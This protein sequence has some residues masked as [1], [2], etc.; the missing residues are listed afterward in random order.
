MTPI[1]RM[2]AIPSCIHTPISVIR[3]LIF[4]VWRPL[5]ILSFHKLSNKEPFMKK[6]LFLVVPLLLLLALLLLRPGAQAAPQAAPAP[7]PSSVNALNGSWE[8]IWRGSGAIFDVDCF[9]E[10]ECLAVGEAGLILAT[11]D[12]GVSWRQQILDAQPDLFAVSVNDAGLALAAGG[13]GALYRS[14]NRGL[15]WEAVTPPTQ[16]EIRDVSLLA[17]GRAWLV[18]AGGLIMHSADGGQTWQTQTSGVSVT[19]YAVQ[20]LN[21]QTGYAAGDKGALLKTTDGGATWVPV[22]HTFPGWARIYTLSFIDEANGYIAGQAGY[23]RKTGDGGQ[24]WQEITSGVATDIFT[25]HAQNNHAIFGG[26]KGVVATSDDGENWTVRASVP[27]DTRDVYAVYTFG[28]GNSWALGAVKDANAAAFFINH[29][30]DGATFLPVAGDY[31]VYP[32]L[33]E[34]A[35]PSRDVAYVVGAEGAIGK[36]LDGGDTWRWQHFQTEF[37]VAPTITGISCPTVDD[38]WI[39]GQVSHNPGFLYVTHD[40]GATWERQNPPGVQWPWLYDVDMV[41]V[42]NGHAAANPYM[43]YTNDGGQTWKESTVVGNTANVEIAMA[44]ATEGWTAQ[45]QLGHRFTTNG[46]R[47]WDRYMPYTEQLS[48]YFFGVDALDVNQDGSL[49]AGWLVGCQGPLVDEQCP[50]NS[51]VIFFASSHQDPGYAQTIPDNTP[52]LYTVTMLDNR[53]GWVGG[54]QGTLLYTET[55]GAIWQNIPSPTTALITEIAFYQ[56]KIGFATTYTGEILRF[57][58]PGRDLNSFTQSTTITVDGEIYDWH[59]GGALDLDADS[60]S[61]VLGAEP[62]PTPDQF[63]IHLYSRWTPETLY[64]MADVND[65]V[66][67]AEDVV[68]FALDGLNDDVWGNAD[69]LLISVTAEGAINADAAETVAHAVVRTA[70]GWRLEL[71]VPASRL[72]RAV[73]EPNTSIGMNLSLEDHDG[74]G[75]VHTLLMEDRTLLD[76]PT[77]WGAIR[78]LN[79]TLTLQ[80]GLN[81]YEGVADTFLTIWG[82]DGRTV[83]GDDESMQVLYTSGRNFSNALL[84]FELPPLLQDATVGRSRLSLYAFLGSANE[85]FQ[86]GAYRLLRP[87]S[88]DVATWYQADAN[89]TWGQPGAL[90]P[91]V[92]FDPTPLDV[93]SLS[94]AISQD[95]LTWD[96]SD[97]VA[98]WQDHPEEN[99]G[100]LLMG[101]NSQRYITVY[102]S[103]YNGEPSQRPK[104]DIDFSLNPRPT[105]TPT[106]SPTP[107]PTPHMLYMP[108]I[109]P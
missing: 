54:A 80:K 71:S 89:T 91:G 78:L 1:Q 26:A 18:G 92:D 35:A 52:Q 33:H 42:N 56:E 104:L 7:S 66:V 4:R 87:W 31:G 88:P 68:T 69:D 50:A 96:I 65:D 40:G 10:D 27:Q 45:R 6:Y 9:T 3:V 70:T 77:V 98:Y 64:L 105:P 95:W 107:T 44:S 46:G 106:P 2:D 84:R 5:H 38:C 29:S 39:A 43:F 62:F 47:L 99:Y 22:N 34:V 93:L 83:H 100:I 25:L 24:T 36:T 101:V 8:R 79:N 55:G 67:G 73:F 11:R 58:G 90:Q 97:A 59:Y 72:G 30:S 57:R 75:V 86:I 102:S 20:F 74:P 109:H 85:G 37:P 15:S 76:N 108:I 17:D 32:A 103:D 49:D 48:I 16:A 61:T 63:S 94:G 19:L 51:G 81:E 28:Q 13:N 23:I 21:A 53:R 82:E 12:R 41:D 60:A 14:I